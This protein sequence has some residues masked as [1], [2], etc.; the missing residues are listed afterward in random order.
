MK[1]FEIIEHGGLEQSLSEHSDWGS[2]SPSV[3]PDQPN[4]ES[5]V[6]RTLA[7]LRKS[8]ASYGHRPSDSMWDAIEDIARAIDEMAEGK[9][10]PIFYTSALDPGVGK[11]QTIVHSVRNL[12]KDV[13]VLICLSRISEVNSLVKDMSLDS[14][15]FAVLVGERNA[16]RIDD[17][18]NDNIDQA[19]VLFTTQQK[20]ETYLKH[21]SK[22]SDLTDFYFND[23]PRLVKIWDESLLPGKEITINIHDIAHSQKAI[24]DLNVS[25][26]DELSDVQGA[27]KSM[28]D[29]DLYRVPDFEQYSEAFKIL[30][31]DRKHKVDREAID[32]LWTLRG[33][34]VRVRRDYK[35]NTILDY[36]ES[37][38][39]DFA[40][41]LICDA[42][43]R[44]RATYALWR[45]KRGNL[46][47]LRHAHKKYRDLTIHHWNRGGGKGAFGD[48]KQRADLVEGV[49]S[50]I[51]S[52]PD[53]EWLVIVHK[54]DGYKLP[55]IRSLILSLV[56]NKDQQ[57]HFLT[58]GDHHATN[59]FVKVSNVILAGTL[60][61]PESTYEVR[62]RAA[63]ALPA[64]DELTP[65]DLRE[66]KLGEYAHG[67]LQAL[68]RGSVRVCVGDGC[69]PMDAYVIAAANTGI[70]EHLPKMFPGCK[71][72][73]WEPVEKPLQGKIR[74][75]VLYLHR[76]F[77]ERPDLP[78]SFRFVQEHLG[79][80][81]K[82]DFNKMIRNDPR[83]KRE[84]ERMN[85]QETAMESQCRYFTHF[86][87][88]Q[89]A[90][91]PL[92][93]TSA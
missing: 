42:S 45:D 31:I 21:A 22:F 87:R 47:Q 91:P 28:K 93:E 30:R 60:F 70:P 78:V 17:F 16:D 41:V 4:P 55:D 77:R 19:R 50:A 46:T 6:E 35:G 74:E 66:V 43:S 37:L 27:I 89:G 81:G 39:D 71:V 14:N 92:P 44:L 61:F 64:E 23:E 13:G 73:P 72:E 56:S 8:F 2:W 11:T 69:A 26:A 63:A 40:P 88:A 3:E 36:T 53:Q 12:R 25:L 58:W 20:V 54:D 48:E 85:V 15:E 65:S 33:K 9:L 5:F 84:L 80:E 24:S 34:H 62:A 82:S 32:A 51:N 52:K 18:G 83:F 57:V 79:I 75:A 7:D 86:A 29:G 76:R 67:I 49:A 10:K 1:T 68:C 90:V 59:Q 38:P